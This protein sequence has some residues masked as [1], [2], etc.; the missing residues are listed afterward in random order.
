VVNLQEENNKK[1]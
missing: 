1:H